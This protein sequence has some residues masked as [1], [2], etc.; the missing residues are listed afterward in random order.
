MGIHGKNLRSPL[1]GVMTD[2][3]SG[4]EVRGGLVCKAHT[5]MYHSTLGSRVIKKKKRKKKNT[6]SAVRDSSNVD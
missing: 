1:C 2:G 6:S 4:T 3:A 5:L